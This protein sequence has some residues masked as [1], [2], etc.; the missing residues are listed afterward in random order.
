MATI[1]TQDSQIDVRHQDA[2]CTNESQ[3]KHPWWYNFKY[4]VVGIIFGIAFVK[5]EII[6]WYRIQEMFQLTSFHMY[7]RNWYGCCGGYDFGDDYQENQSQNYLWRA[8]HT[9]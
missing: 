5:A 6:S 1:Q 8:Y 3:L 4:M 2:I 9:G 7:G